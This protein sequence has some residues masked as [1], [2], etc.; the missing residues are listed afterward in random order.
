MILQSSYYI[1]NSFFIAEKCL[2]NDFEIPKTTLDNRLSKVDTPGE[3]QVQPLEYELTLDN[4]FV[5][6]WTPLWKSKVNWVLLNV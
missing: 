2:N 1:F 4:L 3:V 6:K 5:H